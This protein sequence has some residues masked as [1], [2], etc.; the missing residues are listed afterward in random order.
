M[1]LFLFVFLFVDPNYI[2]SQRVNLRDTSIAFL[3][4]ASSQ[5]TGMDQCFGLRI[6][7]LLVVSR[8]ERFAEFSVALA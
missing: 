5:W 8:T 4:P 6:V 3:G 1:R 2:G 7:K